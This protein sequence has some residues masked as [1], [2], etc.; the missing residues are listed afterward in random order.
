MQPPKESP[1]TVSTAGKVVDV[2]PLKG[3]APMGRRESAN[4][5]SNNGEFKLRNHEPG[6]VYRA[7]L[8]S[9]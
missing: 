5:G 1:R 4:G 7:A 8:L 3:L 6:E 2:S 9:G